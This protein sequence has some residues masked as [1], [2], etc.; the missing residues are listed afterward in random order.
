[1]DAVFL[2]ITLQVVEQLP[3]VRAI[4]DRDVIYLIACLGACCGGKQV[5]LYGVLDI[6][7]VAA[8][9]S[10]S[11]DEDVVATNHCGRPFRND[12]CIRSIRVLALSE[13]IEV[14]QADA[15]ESIA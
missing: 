14:A 7:E 9:Q 4:A 2:E 8:C 11:I 3:E 6:A 1:P 13:H 15:V 5:G 10:V 12:R